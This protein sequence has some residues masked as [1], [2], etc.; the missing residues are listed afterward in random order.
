MVKIA[1]DW[2]PGEARIAALLDNMLVDF[3]L[4]RPGKPDGFGD[5]HCVRI[6]RPAPI[7][8][9]AFGRV[10]TGE[11]VFVTGVFPEG[12]LVTARVTRAAQGGKGARLQPFQ[13]DATCD[14]PTCLQQGPS[15]LEEMAARYPEARILIDTPSLA[16]RLPPDLR[17][18]LERVACT[19]DEDIKDQF[20]A[21]THEDIALPDN[22]SA[23]VTPSA[24]LCAIDLNDANTAAASARTQFD[25]NVAIFPALARQI[26]L[27]NL[28]GVILIDP[29]GV[30][31][32]KRAA[33]I[34]FLQNAFR[35]DPLRP[36]DF[37]ATP[38]GLLELTRPRRRPPL[39]ELLSSPHGIGLAA[40]RQAVRTLSG[41][42]ANR[43]LCLKASFAIIDALQ[44][45]VAASED[46]SQ[47]LGYE[48][49]LMA[50]PDYPPAHWSFS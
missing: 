35:D 9:G 42:P 45:D 14:A 13:L 5:I 3:S 15:P 43:K 40:L 23:H 22:M 16:V 44:K 11:D 17:P 48:L 8:K 19:F 33:L 24:A 1:V 20:S 37:G 38:S 32:R 25:R 21:L 34:P 49:P 6:T 2:S 31:T 30:P 50:I 7:M 36:H 26:R 27:R 41:M 47:I 12:A 18:R 10:E 4:W 28:N 46:V 29:A 39:H